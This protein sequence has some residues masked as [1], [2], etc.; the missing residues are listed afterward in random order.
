LPQASELDA[1]RLPEPLKL[2]QTIWEAARGSQLLFLVPSARLERLR[3]A[4]PFMPR[5]ASAMT[6]DLD[7]PVS[8][9]RDA[10]GRALQTIDSRVLRANLNAAISQRLTG[11]TQPEASDERVAQL[12]MSR[13]YLSTLLAQAPDPFIAIGPDGGMLAWNA[14]AATVFGRGAETV[15][16][17]AYRDVLPAPLADLIGENL[18]TILLGE[19]S[20]QDVETEFAITG[21]EQRCFECRMAPVRGPARELAS[22]SISLRDV[23]DRRATEARLRESEL[24]YRTLTEALPQLVWTCLP[25]GRC[26]F[27]GQ[28]WIDYTGIP[29]EAQLG[30]AWLDL[31]VHPDDRARTLDHWMGAVDSVHPYDIEYRIRRHDGVYRWFK[32]RGTPLRDERGEIVRWFGT[33]TDIEDVVQAREVLARSA[34]ELEARV[35]AEMA[36]RVKAEEA[37]R[38]AQKMEAVGQLT[39]G[40]AHDFNNLLQG[41]TG[42]LDLI[43]K[44]IEQGKVKEVA[45]FLQAARA[46]ANRAASLTHRLLAFSRRQALTP[47]PTAPTKLARGMAD[48]LH[49]SLGEHIMLEYRLDDEAWS[50]LCDPVQLESSVLNLAL[51]ARD[52][53]PDGGV[54]TISTRNLDLK[55]DDPLRGPDMD[56]G[57]YV[58]IEVKDTGVGMPP[59][60]IARAFDPFFTTKPTG[61]GTGLGLSMVYGFARQSGG[62]VI[63][64]SAVSQGTS[65]SILLPR[66]AGADTFDELPPPTRAEPSRH[67]EVVLVVEDEPTVREL[68][69]QALQELH[70][71][72]LAAHDGPSGLK[73]LDSAD[74][75]DLLVTDIGLPGLNG[76]QLADV[77]RVRRPNLPVLFMTGYAEKAAL[78]TGVLDRG[79]SLIAKPFAIVTLAQR[80]REI[81]QAEPV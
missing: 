13:D 6:L 10:F 19:Y 28:Q 62:N 11:R 22:I 47:K 78:G 23:S 18:Q 45:R 4:L 26:D 55:P 74:S 50:A 66:Y 34:A 12:T 69:V 16:G 67:G 57:P 20:R 63:L 21:G 64:E 80:V 53:M 37:L 27:L 76:R 36:E 71:Q 9:L 48:L 81:L 70:Y 42:A 38:Q 17:H 15:L 73:L 24:R 46:S 25:D 1:A 7:A 77:A 72:V 32:T 8:A 44:R 31:V 5:L 35:A 41:I 65:V 68:I 49:R 58:C 75:I 30:F 61:Q 54:L 33:S 52:A 2:A 51:N 29:K 60:V 59:D 14:A 43:A 39:G 40:I 79:M 3:S 56:P